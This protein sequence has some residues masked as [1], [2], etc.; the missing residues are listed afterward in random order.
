MSAN[1][2]TKQK[3]SKYTKKKQNKLVVFTS[4]EINI[5]KN[6]DIDFDTLNQIKL[7]KDVFDC[8]VIS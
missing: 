4:E 1:L 5:L 2:N 7:F 8:V 6:K 3:N